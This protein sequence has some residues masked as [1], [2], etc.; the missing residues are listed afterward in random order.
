MST[1]VPAKLTRINFRTDEETKN[2]A[3]RIFTELGMDMSTALNMFLRQTIHDQGLPFSPTL[4]DIPNEETR[5]AMVEAEAKTMGIIPDDS[6]KFTNA[7][8]AMQWLNEAV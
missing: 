3:N 1:V 8:D 5:R 6:P 4:R 2:A 7:Q